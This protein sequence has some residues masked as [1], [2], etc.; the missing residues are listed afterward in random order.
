MDAQ[1]NTDRIFKKAFTT[2]SGV[3]SHAEDKKHEKSCR[4]HRIQHGSNIG[5]ISQNVSQELNNMKGSKSRKKRLLST[6]TTY[7]STFKNELKC[8]N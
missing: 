1:E 3:K 4:R 5:K 8:H 7:T 2:I 6:K